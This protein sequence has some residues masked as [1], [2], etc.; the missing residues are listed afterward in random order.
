MRRGKAGYE[1]TIFILLVIIGARI[2]N[3]LAKMLLLLSSLLKPFVPSIKIKAYTNVKYMV[4][5]GWC[6]LS[7]VHPL[8][9][10]N[11]FWRVDI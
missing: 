1:A 5:S 8:I 9:K 11:R 4:F 10:P 7:C 6:F 3:R 2:H